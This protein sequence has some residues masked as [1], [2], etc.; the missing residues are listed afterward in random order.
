MTARED[1]LSSNPLILLEKNLSSRLLRRAFSGPRGCVP[2]LDIEPCW[3]R[4][5]PAKVAPF[6]PGANNL[7]D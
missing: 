7:E 6:Y 3:Y 4:A 2:N 1:D 5:K